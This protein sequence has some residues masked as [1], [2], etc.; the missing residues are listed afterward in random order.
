MQSLIEVNHLSSILTLCR[1]LQ[2]IFTVAKAGEEKSGG[3]I[4]VFN[5]PDMEVTR[6][7]LRAIH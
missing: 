1:Q 4:Q 6:H 5:S 7:H 3:G 2:I